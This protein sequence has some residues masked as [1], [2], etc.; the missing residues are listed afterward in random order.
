MELETKRYF[1]DCCQYNADF[2]IC[3]FNATKLAEAPLPYITSGFLYCVS[4]IVVLRWICVGIGGAS[5]P[6]ERAIRSVAET[7]VRDK[8]LK[9]P[10]QLAGC[11]VRVNGVC[12]V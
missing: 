1:L 6:S 12:Y 7:L 5:S 3:R 11:V 8:T 4:F 10:M 9:K 2:G